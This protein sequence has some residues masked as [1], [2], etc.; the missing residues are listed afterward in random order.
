MIG[1][2]T[3]LDGQELEPCSAN[4]FLNRCSNKIKYKSFNLE[5]NRELYRLIKIYS[6]ISSF[7]PGKPR[8]NSQIYLASAYTFVKNCMYSMSEQF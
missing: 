8:K 3:F 1:Q 5:E 6:F 4:N 2:K 7:S